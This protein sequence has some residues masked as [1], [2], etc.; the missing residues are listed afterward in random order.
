MSKNGKQ[1][2]FPVHRL[3]ADAFISNPENKPFVNHINADTQDNRLENLEWATPKENAEHTSSLDRTKNKIVYQYDLQGNFIQEFP[4]AKKASKHYDMVYGTLLAALSDN[5]YACGYQW[6]FADDSTPI[7]EY[8]DAREKRVMQYS[9]DGTYIQ[10]FVSIA[11][12][13]TFLQKNGVPNA[14][15]AN[16]SKA[17]TGVRNY[18]YEFQWRH[19]GDERPLQ[20]LRKKVKSIVQLSLNGE[21]I[22]THEHIRA[23]EIHLNLNLNTSGIGK[24]CRGKGKSAHGFKWMYEEDYKNSIL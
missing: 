6:K 14:N 17:C 3:V 2:D 12:A 5:H 8:V 22:K 4:S 15:A 11:D 19:E 9:M 21:F 18:S 7:G 23:A 24:C 13:E 1:K 20:T 10:T 16:I